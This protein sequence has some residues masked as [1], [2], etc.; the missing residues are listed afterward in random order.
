MNMDEKLS[1]MVNLAFNFMSNEDDFGVFLQGYSAAMVHVHGLA[2]KEMVDPSRP[3]EK[4]E[5]C[6]IA[7]FDSFMKSKRQTEAMH[8]DMPEPAKSLRRNMVG[9]LYDLMT[10]TKGKAS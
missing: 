10:A 5:Q 8:V 2:L 1:G 4:P 7:L 9:E 3:P 6:L